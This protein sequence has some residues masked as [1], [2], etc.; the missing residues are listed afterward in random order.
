[1]FNVT[2][3]GKALAPLGTC[4]TFE[5]YYLLI[6]WVYILQTIFVHLPMYFH[7]NGNEM[8]SL[9]EGIT[10][11][12]FTNRQCLFIKVELHS[13]LEGNVFYLMKFWKR[14]YLAG[15]ILGF[16]KIIHFLT[17]SHYLFFLTV[18]SWVSNESTG[19]L[20]KY[21]PKIQAVRNFFCGT[22]DGNSRFWTAVLLFQPPYS[23]AK[24]PKCL[25]CPFILRLNVWLAH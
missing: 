4:H 6:R 20:K 8:N 18:Y 10:G 11:F 1:M 5:G 17:P 21:H 3:E 23:T 13:A 24:L 9:L 25:T 14:K 15:Q 7:P 22:I 12:S 16:E 2:L 19:T